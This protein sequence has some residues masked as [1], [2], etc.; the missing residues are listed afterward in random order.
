MY[1]YKKQKMILILDDFKKER[2][3]EEIMKAFKHL[4]AV[5]LTVVL[6][7]TFASCYTISGQKMRTVKGT[8]QLTQYTYTPK[9]ER[10]EGYTPRTFN[11][12]ED[13]EYQYEDYLIITGS[14]TGY[15]VH[16]EAGSDAYVK[17][18][19]L[20]YEYDD[21]NS[22]K[23]EYVIFNDALT[24]NKNTEFNKMGVTK[25]SLNYTKNSFDYNELFTKKPMRS[26]ALTVRW[27]K[28]SRDTD[29]K[30][31]EQELGEL[32]KYDYNAFGKKGIYQRN[33]PWDIETGV[34]QE[35]P[36][37]YFYY[38]I[39]TA[40]NELKATAY[41]ALKETPGEKVVR[42]YQIERISDDWSILVIDGV[43][44]TLEQPYST[45]YYNDTDGMRTTLSRVSSDISDKRL[46]ELIDMWLPVGQ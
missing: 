40:E 42:E 33:A 34:V 45:N 1:L 32:K 17:E 16:K 39:D 22:S 44:W 46:G 19:T 20:S 36:Y 24:V 23:V 2:I 10:K 18:V 27:T 11:Y 14:G 13:E 4:L 3:K 38:V 6:M 37:Q 21:E 5:I 35:S 8:Y 28:A 15:Y 12:L 30:Y 41:Y 43:E 31:V 9:Y 25:N 29:L 26:E 7:L